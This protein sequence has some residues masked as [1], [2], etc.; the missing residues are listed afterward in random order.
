MAFRAWLDAHYRERGLFM[1]L[2]FSLELVAVITLFLLMLLTCADV[3]GRYLFNNSIDGAIE[4][5]RIGLAIM[6]FA[7]LPVIS[8]RGGHVVVD[9]LDSIVSHR[10]I[11]VFSMLAAL[12]IATSLYFVAWRIWE[13][14]ERS[15]RRG[16]V[17]EYLKFPEGYLIYYIALMS[18]VTAA[19][20][21]TY[22]IYHLWV[23]PSDNQLV[24]D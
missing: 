1:W 14:A 4:L 16:E 23:T 6:V 17:T 5:T 18:W 21:I 3:T 22:G 19:T 11:R 24:S 8:W 2:A 9:L 15:L 12:L 20:M 7:E 10:L 13:L